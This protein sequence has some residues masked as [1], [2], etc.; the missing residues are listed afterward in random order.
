MWSA[1]ANRGHFLSADDGNFDSLLSEQLDEFRLQGQSF[2]DGWS[3]MHYDSSATSNPIS[4]V[5]SAVSTEINGAV[6]DS[7][8][9]SILDPE[10]NTRVALGH[11]RA[12]TS[13]AIEIPNPHP[14]VYYADN[15]YSF[16]HNGTLSKD[17]L[18]GL[19]TDN[20]ADSSW[21]INHPPSSY[22]NGDWR[23][24]GWGAVVDSEL[25]F[26]WIVKNIQELNFDVYGGII[27]AL[28]ALN[29][30][31]PDA[32]EKTM[33][34]SDGSKLYLY[35]GSAKLFFTDGV[36]PLENPYADVPVHFK[37]V[38]TVPPESGIASYLPWEPLPEN[39]IV[40]LSAEGVSTHALSTITSDPFLPTHVSLLPNYPNPFNSST[41]VQ[42]DLTAHTEIRL[43]VVDISGRKITVLREGFESAGLHSIRWNSA[44]AASGVYTILLE[45]K[46][47][48]YSRKMVLIK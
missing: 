35:G 24:A 14:F 43:S 1:I 6:Y 18:L 4:I 28:M 29:T 9:V 41:L 37:A 26:L 17:V 21:I 47:G 3:L 38:M 7:V 44:G 25:Y 16:I 42:F 11:L 20:G 8:V 45:T 10:S 22:G 46:D 13:G 40:V 23:N 27:Q 34:F 32:D 36:T 33:I 31:I 30:L 15:C 2:N 39:E 12:G 19:L 48:V 5:R